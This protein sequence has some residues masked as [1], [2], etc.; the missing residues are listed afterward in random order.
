[1]KVAEKKPT[2]S[3]QGGKANFVKTRR[4]KKKSTLSRQGGIK[5]ANFVNTS[6]Q[7]NFPPIK[8]EKQKTTFKVK[9]KAEKEKTTFRDQGWKMEGN[10]LKEAG[11]VLK[12]GSNTKPIKISRL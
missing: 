12:S 9:I 2:L 3:K 7:V 5:E 10:F 8:A 11:K 6:R 1:M 4:Q